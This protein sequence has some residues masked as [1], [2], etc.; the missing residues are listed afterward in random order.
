MKKLVSLLLAGLTLF[1]LA[2]CSG[3]GSGGGGT[4]AP[5]NSGTGEGGAVRTLTVANWQ[6]YGSDAEYAVQAFEEANN[7]KVVHQYFDSEEAL[8]NMLRQGG[9]GQI[10]VVLPN[11]AYVAIGKRENLFQPIDVSRLENY[12]DLREDIRDVEDV[13]DADGNILGVPWTWGTTSLGYNPDAISD[14]VDS[15]GIL[16]DPA[17]QNKIAFFDDHTTAVMIAAT[18]AG[19]DPYDPDLD[20]VKDTLLSLKANCKLFW[21]SY[22]SFAKP[23]SAG[24]V[25]ARQRLV[26]CRH[27]A[28]RHRPEDDLCLSQGGYHRL[29]GL[30]GHSQGRAQRGSGLQV[31]R[32]DDLSAVPVHLCRR[33]G[34]AAPHPLQHQ[35]A[36]Q[37]LRR[38]EGRPV[39]RQRPAG[40]AGVPERDPGGDQPGLAGPVERGQGLLSTRSSTGR[41]IRAAVSPVLFHHSEKGGTR[42][43]KSKLSTWLLMLPSTGMLALLV[44]APLAVLVFASLI[45]GNNLALDAALSLGNYA[46]ILEKGL[47]FR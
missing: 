3:G 18:Y 46:T 36:G 35:G 1:S 25:V 19:E 27:P 23:Y 29:G 47:F 22:D 6:G 40:E 15:W 17:Y 39:R 14:T 16:W 42:M 44:V 10:D 24:E 41:R 37:S 7:C 11:M 38:C 33:S 32:L 45:Q 5:Q 9:L 34:D 21:S 8:L 43:T 31:D 12:G 30:L 2:A 20:V 28:Q 4:A 13:K 26:R